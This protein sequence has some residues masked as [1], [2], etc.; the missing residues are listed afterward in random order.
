[1]AVPDGGR[2]RLT[3]KAMLPDVQRLRDEL[4]E[5]VH[6]WQY[7]YAMGHGCTVGDHPDFQAT[8]QRVAD[9]RARIA[10]L[11]E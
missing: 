11:T 10:E 8:R 6:S 1:M 2:A 9:L 3:L 4:K 7:A 5:L